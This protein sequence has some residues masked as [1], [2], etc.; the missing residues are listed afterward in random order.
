MP[1]TL[2]QRVL[3]AILDHQLDLMRVEAGTRIKIIRLLNQL[4]IDL[5]GQL[6]NRNLT[7]TSKA[8]L[9]TLLKQSNETIEHYYTRIQGQ[10]SE[11][12]REIAQIQ[13]THTASL[14]V[15]TE[16]SLPTETFLTRLATNVLIHGS[17]AADWWSRQS[18]DTAFKFANQVRQGVAQGETNEQIVARI[19]GKPRLGI[20]G[21]MEIP[22]ANARSLVHSSIQT[23]ANAARFE[24]FRK[25]SDIVAGV[26]QVSTFDSHTTDICIAYDGGMWDLDGEPL[27]DTDLPFVNDEGALTGTPR[28]WGCRSVLVPITH[29]VAGMKEPPPVQRPG[30]A[31]SMDDFLDSR[32]DEQLD[33]QLGPG[34]AQLYRE[35]KIT[36]QQ[37][38]DL[39]GNP[40][41]TTDLKK[42]Y[43]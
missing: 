32:T 8:R 2:D 31:T 10:M 13:A 18:Q 30:G 42:K 1:D 14:I 17:P 16:A 12:M 26:R 3:D 6:M 9:Q 21:V 36:R 25:N 34:R 5:A 40:M 27:G 38:L 39:S 11:T 24:T 15:A 19:T 35:G 29:R 33:E 4:Q 28:H 23:V 43:G 22:K 20:A 37:L 41:T 7:E